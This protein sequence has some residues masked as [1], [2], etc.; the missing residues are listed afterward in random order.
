MLS[1]S[2]GIDPA[3]LRLKNGLRTG[4]VSI[5]G[6][7]IGSSGLGECIEKAIRASSWKEKGAQKRFARG[8]GLACCNH[9]SGN[10]AFAREFDGGGGIVR[11]G[12]E[13]KALVYHGESDM[14]QGQKTI[15][16]QIVAEELGIPL[17]RVEVSTV[18]TEI[19]PFGL[20]SFA[21][22]GTVFGG[23]GVKAAAAEAKKQV[24]ESAAGLLE[25]SPS[26][27]EARGGRIFVKGSPAHGL[28]FQK[29][30]ETAV[31]K[32]G[33]APIVG[34]GFWVPDTEL[35]DPVTKYGNIAPAYPF[36]CQIAEVEVDTETG[37]V[38]LK[39]YVAAHD[40]GRAINPQATEGQIEGG[41]AQGIGWALMENMVTEKGKII[42]P[43]FRDYVLPGPLDLPPIQSILVEP[44]EP[45]GPFGAKGI[46]EPALNPS[47]AAVANAIYN[48]IGIR[49]TELPLTPE[50]IL[51]ALK[52]KEKREE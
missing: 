32:R 41:V 17:D 33:G 28:P 52:A 50:K 44:V 43:D 18:D 48:A 29:V 25:C 20:G 1:E 39:N 34:T 37:Q 6:W 38:H 30:V 26:D 10:R 2:L 5:H 42:N 45:N 23:N 49:M 27:L 8:I 22:R 24:L 31:Y 14:G 47:P 15:F 51:T 46:G 16:A 12:R 9:V 3:E 21:T 13:G 11:I 36:A 35:P 19:S 40:V 4:E 7:K